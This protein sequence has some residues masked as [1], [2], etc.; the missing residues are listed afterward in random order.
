MSALSPSV[1]IKRLAQQV[2]TVS[3]DL[4]FPP[5]CAHCQRVGYLLCSRC[6]ATISAAPARSLPQFEDVRVRAIYGGVI[7]SAIHALKYKHQTRLAGP[8]GELLCEALCEINWTVDLVTAVPMH[9]KRLRERGYNQAALLGEVVAQQRGWAFSSSAVTRS[10]ETLSQVHLN[11]QERQENVADAFCSE[12]GIV[13]GKS[14]L[15]IDDVLTT[16]ATMSAC[17][18]ALR[19]A[20]AARV[21]GAAVA[22]AAYSGNAGA[23][24]APV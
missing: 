4:L 20:G 17:A 18:E 12:S 22:S 10:R 5:H 14:V 3:L 1:R 7:S 2:T 21:Y 6:L 24:D 13:A 15:I 8:L 23:S 11:A 16:G 19:A 9:T